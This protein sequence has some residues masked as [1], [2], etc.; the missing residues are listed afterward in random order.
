M[1]SKSPR[2][3]TPPNPDTWFGRHAQAMEFIA[4]HF[5]PSAGRVVAWVVGIGG[6]MNEE[7]V[8]FTPTE[9]LEVAEAFQKAGVDFR[10][11]ALDTSEDVIQQAK[12]DLKKDEIVVPA[13]HPEVRQPKKT[14]AAE[15]TRIAVSSDWRPRIRLHGPGDAGDIFLA[16]PEEK[17]DVVTIF[18]VARSYHRRHQH[19]LARI[20]ADALK[21]GGVLLTNATDNQ[22]AFITALSDALGTPQDLGATHDEGSE[23]KMVAFL[24][25]SARS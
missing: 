18:N 8:R 6:G 16:R 15:K 4:R 2:P 13:R 12:D 24:K 11:H 1:Q 17:P 20:L 23:G 14:S 25:K 9:H 22:A 5:Q 19:R 3:R 7:G 21:G 10:I